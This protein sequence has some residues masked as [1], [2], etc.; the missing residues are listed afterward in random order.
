[1]M[2]ILV[3]LVVVVFSFLG[4]VVYSIMREIYRYEKLTGKKGFKFTRQQDDCGCV[5]GKPRLTPQELDAEAIRK[6]WEA[7]GLELETVLNKLRED[8]KI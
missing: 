3:L 6:D 7:V 5:K 4:W 1:M 8:G 2:S